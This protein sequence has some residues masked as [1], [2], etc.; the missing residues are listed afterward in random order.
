MNVFAQKAKPIR[1]I[2]VNETR[3]DRFKE[4][5]IM[6][7]IL[8]V[9]DAK[10]LGFCVAIS[11]MEFGL[12]RALPTYPTEESLKRERFQCSKTRFKAVS[13]VRTSSV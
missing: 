5:I 8:F 13:S 2:Y 7:S 10:V 9:A 3:K 6:L 4:L 11:E 1:N 12:K